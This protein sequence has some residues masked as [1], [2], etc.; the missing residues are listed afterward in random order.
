MEPLADDYSSDDGMDAGGK[1]CSK[2]ELSV[3][4]T[5]ANHRH[6]NIMLR[7]GWCSISKLRFL[8]AFS[9]P[10]PSLAL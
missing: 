6:D 4:S 8:S 3:S 5:I 10:V 9:S 7:S 1:R 2:G